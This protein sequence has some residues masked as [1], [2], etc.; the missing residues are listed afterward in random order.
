M[1]E[2]SIVVPAMAFTSCTSNNGKHTIA[3]TRVSLIPGRKAE[4]LGYAS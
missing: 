4:K 3:R 2:P 1:S